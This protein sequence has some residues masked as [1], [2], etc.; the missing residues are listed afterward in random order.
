MA[1][2]WPTT[3]PSFALQVVTFLV[4]GAVRVS[5]RPLT[6]QNPDP[7]KKTYL[8]HKNRQT[9]SQE[10]ERDFDLTRTRHVRRHL[11]A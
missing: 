9:P 10:E 5:P 1:C 3:V 6:I 7:V 2:A 4:L 11:T 8:Q